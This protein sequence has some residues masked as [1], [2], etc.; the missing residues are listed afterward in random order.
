MTAKADRGMEKDPL[1]KLDKGYVD[2]VAFVAG[3]V[4]VS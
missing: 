4:A 2:M 1:V 3:K